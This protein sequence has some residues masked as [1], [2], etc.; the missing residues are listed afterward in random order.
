MSMFQLFFHPHT[1]IF[2]PPQKTK[3]AV[4]QTVENEYLISTLSGDQ[5][6]CGICIRAA[7]SAM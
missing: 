1:R 3:T 2:Q 7:V 6:T 4:D 5:Q